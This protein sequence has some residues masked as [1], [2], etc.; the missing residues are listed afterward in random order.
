MRGAAIMSLLIGPVALAACGPIPLPQ[1]ERVCMEDA[2]MA[3]APRGSVG[4]GIGSGG[5]SRAYGSFEI[6]VS[7]DYIMGRDPA[8]VYAT[9]VK[10][11]SGYPPSRPLY[12]HPGWEG[13]RPARK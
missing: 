13:Y 7:S 5:H 2:Y 11:R 9:C 6:S 3:R 10:R 4:V 12:E 1:A 8:E